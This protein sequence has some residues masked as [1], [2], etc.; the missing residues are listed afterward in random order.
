MI[1]M[2]FRGLNRLVRPAQ[3]G[4]R[5]KKELGLFFQSKCGEIF[6]KFI[7]LC[8]YISTKSLWTK[9]ATVLGKLIKNIVKICVFTLQ[10]F[11]AKN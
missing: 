7:F 3:I 1:G 9:Y 11:T 6:S 5:K 8:T 2:L 4:Y 10:I